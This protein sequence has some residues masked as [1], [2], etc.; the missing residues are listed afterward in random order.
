MKAK[1]LLLY[2]LF[3]CQLFANENKEAALNWAT[4]LADSTIAEHPQAWRMRKSDG[5]YRWSYAQGL[6]LSGVLSIYEIK[7]NSQYEE[8]VRSYLDHYVDQKGAIA[9]YQMDEFNIDSINSGKL[10]FHFYDK[11]KEERY[12][13]AINLLRHQL[14]WHPRTR[15]G[16]F[17]HKRKYPWQIWLDGLYMA[18]PFYAKY[19]RKFNHDKKID[20]V[21]LQFSESNKQLLD[22]NTGLLFHGYDESRIQSWAD[23]KTGRSPQFWSRA[24]GWYAMALVDTIENIETRKSRKE[25]INILQPLLKA[26][27]QYQDEKTGLWYQV[28]DGQ[29]KEGNYLEASASAMFVYSFAK[30][31]RL[32]LVDISFKA[33]AWRGFAGFE[34]HLLEY[35][36]NSGRVT[37]NQV[38]RSAGLG[39]DPYRDGS[40]DYY[41]NQTDK[42]SN[43]AHGIGSLLLALVELSR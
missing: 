35:D 4:R 17:W 6:V 38:C 34:K 2:L 7:P 5:E 15:S 3:S 36:A 12:L 10:L 21:V 30:A 14:D 8:Y 40:Y 42:V 18:A 23:P 22:R 20:D 29:G 24:L 13:K 11:T 32:G 41:V 37:L 26:I 27:A 25:L 43:D 16:V 39:G 33:A 1:L 19:E 9:T 31:E 28:T